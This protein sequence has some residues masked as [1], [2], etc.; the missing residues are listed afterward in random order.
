MQGDIIRIVFV[1]RTRPRSVVLRT[2]EDDLFALMPTLGR[3]GRCFSGLKLKQ[4][5]GACNIAISL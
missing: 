5:V 1:L 2:A 4:E 3:H